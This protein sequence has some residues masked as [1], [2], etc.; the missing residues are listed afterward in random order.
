VSQRRTAGASGI[1]KVNRKRGRTRKAPPDYAFGNAPVFSSGTLGVDGRESCA[2]GLEAK[3]LAACRRAKTTTDPSVAGGSAPNKANGDDVDDDVGS[4]GVMALD[5][6]TR[7][8]NVVGPSSLQGGVVV[9]AVADVVGVDDVFCDVRR[10]K[11]RRVTDPAIE[12]AMEKARMNATGFVG[13]GF[14]RGTRG[15]M[16]R[17][18]TR[19]HTHHTDTHTRVTASKQCSAHATPSS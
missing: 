18:P 6:G 19:A 8:E 15:G 16:A 9:A 7:L 3:T 2:L 5:D 1:V 13:K 14:T 17:D 4:G 10:K 11:A 12:E